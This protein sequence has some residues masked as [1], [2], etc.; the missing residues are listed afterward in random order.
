MTFLEIL[1]LNKVLIKILNMELM[2]LLNNQIKLM[3][4]IY[5]RSKTK[6]A[7]GKIYPIANI[8]SE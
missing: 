7:A 3:I 6:P 8:N 1:K 5:L 2:L 4:I